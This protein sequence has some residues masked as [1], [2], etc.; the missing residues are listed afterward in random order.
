[1]PKNYLI[2]KNEI[3]ES[4]K[5]GSETIQIAKKYNFSNATIIRQLKNMMGSELTINLKKENHHQI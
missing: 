3:L 4:F 1:M 2:F 5:E